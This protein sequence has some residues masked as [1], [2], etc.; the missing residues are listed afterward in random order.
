[1]IGLNVSTAGVIDKKKKKK[2]K[3][4]NTPQRG[5]G[6]RGIHGGSATGQ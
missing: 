6:V 2:K 5:I 4:K 1:M 3:K